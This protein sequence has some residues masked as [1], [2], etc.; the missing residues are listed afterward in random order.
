[1]LPNPKRL[2][3]ALA[4]LLSFTFAGCITPPTAKKNVGETLSRYEAGKTTFRDFKRDARLVY[5]VHEVDNPFYGR[6][7]IPPQPQPKKN[8]VKGWQ[9][10]PGSSWKIYQTS[11]YAYTIGP[12]MAGGPKTVDERNF[13]VGDLEH[14]LFILTFEAETVLKRITPIQR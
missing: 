3:P 9:P 13:A 12:G 14:P 2:A 10:A 1:M 4:C 7:D 8:K 5:A 11:T 6:T